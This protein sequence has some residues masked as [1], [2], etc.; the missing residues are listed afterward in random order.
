M[1][2]TK[3]IN[4]PKPLSISQLNRQSRELLEGH[5]GQVWVE[6]EIS[7]F[8]RAAS[9]HCY[10]SLKD[11][12]AQ[13]RCALF[14]GRSR[15]LS[16]RPKNGMQ[17][18][19]RGKISLYEPRGDYQF[20]VEQ[21]EEV[22]SGL[23]QR[24]FE[25]LKTALQAE[26][27]FA[28]EKKQAIPR[29]PTRL[30]VITSSK[31]AALHDVLH[32]LKRRYPSLPVIVYPCA[33]QGKTA[34]TEIVTA[35]QLA[36][37]R[38]ECD[39]L[40]LV[41]G[42]G[43][44]EDLWPFNEEIVAETIFACSLPII[45]GIG[46]EIDFTISDFV[47]DLRAPT[48]SAAAE[49]ATPDQPELQQQIQ[50]RQQRLTQLIKQKQA[51]AKNRLTHLQQRL[52]LQHPKQQIQRQTQ[53]LDQLESRLIRGLKQRLQQQQR[54]LF[55]LSERLSSHSPHKK[56]QQQSQTLSQLQQ[57]LQNAQTKQLQQQRLKLAALGRTLHA[58]SPLATL[59][60]GYSV[61][62]SLESKNIVHD[63]KTLSIGESIETQFSQG[64]VVSKVERIA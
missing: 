54:H 49:L 22:G 6:G 36:Q 34:A 58:V 1:P 9:G 55:Q 40:L 59:G 30:G 10:F 29:F 35:L 62:R 31:G 38:A 43:S 56:L 42:G 45:S 33:V 60:R 5:L 28:A 8:L 44:L 15:Y 7:N 57:R 23:L 16:C 26:G 3:S 63:S 32:V 39:L 25:A 51:D 41:R 53:Q 50:H 27:L 47:A 21:L 64:T 52:H 4:S 18:L 12:K 14:K 2:N 19:A 11:S 20:I 46:H 48:P 37:Q 17:V 61:T 13:I 24:K